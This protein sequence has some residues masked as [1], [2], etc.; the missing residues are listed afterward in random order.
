MPSTAPETSATATDDERPDTV[1]ANP[2]PTAVAWA[3]A[4]L[5]HAEYPHV[6][7]FQH[8]M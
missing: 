2:L 5:S 4:K 8:A 1:V 3:D 6:G 7:V